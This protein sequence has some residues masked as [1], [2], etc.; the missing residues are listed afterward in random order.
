MKRAAE[1]AVDSEGNPVVKKG[2]GRPP[3]S[4]GKKAK[5]AGKAAKGVRLVL[6]DV[7]SSSYYTGL[8]EVCFAVLAKI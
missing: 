2:R 1:P 3:G 6:V 4:G 7:M 5:K 8:S